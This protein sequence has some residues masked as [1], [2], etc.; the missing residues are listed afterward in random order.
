MN[1]VNQTASPTKP[2]L[3][4]ALLGGFDTIANHLGLILF[5]IT[6]DLFLWFGPH[7]RIKKLAEEVANQMIG[8]PGLDSP[9]AVQAMQLNRELWLLVADRLNLFSA[10]RSYPVGIP[11]LMAARQPLEMPFGLPAFLELSTPASVAAM[12]LFISLIGMVAGVLYFTLVAQASLDGKVAIRTALEQWP[13]STWQVL[14]L[15]LLLGVILVA[16]SIPGSCLVTAASFS[17]FTV[18]QFSFLLF[19]A[20]ALWVL[21]PLFLSVH[22]IFTFQYKM[23]ASVRQGARL[24]RMTLTTTSL[25]FLGVIVISKGLDTLWS[26]PPENSW[27]SLVGLGGHAFVSTSLLAATFIY[28][29]DASHWV[30]RMIQQS[31]FLEGKNITDKVA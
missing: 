20:L 13:W 22:G 21:F 24:T 11:S 8:L 3:I 14:T 31:L 5:P 16:I 6:L 10:L 26:V 19:G 29:R 23:W 27:L 30:Q 7:L 12:W 1:A 4:T 25:L 18:A 15:T 9:E 2:S 28:Y 17:G